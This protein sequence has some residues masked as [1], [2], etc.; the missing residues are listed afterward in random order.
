MFIV[1]RTDLNLKPRRSG[2]LFGERQSSTDAAS[3]RT[4]LVMRKVPCYK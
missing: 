3:E 4:V 1:S 2:K